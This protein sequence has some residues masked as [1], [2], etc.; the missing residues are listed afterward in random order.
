[1]CVNGKEV[2]FEA[3]WSF[4]VVQKMCEK[5]SVKK[6]REKEC[7]YF[8]QSQTDERTGSSEQVAV[9]CFVIYPF[10]KHPQDPP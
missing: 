2:L 9:S 7:S 5:Q 6:M 8:G 3:D 1:M 4:K 10:I